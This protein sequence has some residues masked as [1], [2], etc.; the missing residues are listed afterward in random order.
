MKNT[1]A[2]LYKRVNWWHSLKIWPIVHMQTPILHP[3]NGI[4][5]FANTKNGTTPWTFSS[6]QRTFLF[7]P[8]RFF[9]QKFPKF[10]A[11]K[12]NRNF[13]F[14]Q[15]VSVSLKFFF[16]ISFC[17]SCHILWKVWVTHERENPVSCMFRLATW[18]LCRVQQS[19]PTFLQQVQI[20]RSLVCSR[21]HHSS[22]ASWIT[23]FYNDILL[24]L[25]DLENSLIITKSSLHLLKKIKVTLAHLQGEDKPYQL[26]N[27]SLVPNI[28]ISAEIFIYIYIYI[29][30]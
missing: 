10:P 23:A 21:S 8:E 11:L 15:N 16:R 19:A 14:Y 4:F 30:M 2:F 25:Q 18:L 24:C 5:Q 22:P 1:N 3:K 13:Q 27:T 12:I 17:H 28:A 29:Y 20:S 7:P 9:L 26:L 6:P